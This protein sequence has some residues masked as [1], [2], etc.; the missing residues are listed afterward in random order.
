MLGGD[1]WGGD[2]PTQ[3]GHYTASVQAAQLLSVPKELA[4]PQVRRLHANHRF[5]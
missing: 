5:G 1:F 4:S 2:L 3:A